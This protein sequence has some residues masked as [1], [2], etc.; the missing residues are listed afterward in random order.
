MIEEIPLQRKVVPIYNAQVRLIFCFGFVSAVSVWGF[1]SFAGILKKTM[2]TPSARN[3]K[4][5]N[6][7]NGSF[8]KIK[9]YALG[10]TTDIAAIGLVK[11][12]GPVF[13]AIYPQYID[14][15]NVIPYKI[16]Q[17]SVGK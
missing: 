11:E 15:Q 3:P 9:E 7:V 6:N 13:S 17:K 14:A 1:F 8:K 16:P 12:S 2:E 5:L 4:I 10:M